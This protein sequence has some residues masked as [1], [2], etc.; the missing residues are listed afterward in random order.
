M[1]P[2]DNYQYINKDKLIG[3]ATEVE[4]MD[5]VQDLAK[6]AAM[7]E[8]INTEQSNNTATDNQPKVRRVLTPQDNLERL[9]D[10]LK[11]FVIR[12]SINLDNNEQTELADTLIEFSD[13]FSKNDLDLGC[14]DEIKL[15]I[16][17]ADATPIRQNMR[18]TPFNF[19]QEEEEHL[20]SMLKT[21]VISPSNSEWASCPVLVRKKD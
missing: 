4:V 8:I 10:H 2:T 7:E 19:E 20:E 21:N 3:I 12:S 13:V 9:P 15:N 17:T 14:F 16:N 1:N 6:N 5:D 11:D 18:R